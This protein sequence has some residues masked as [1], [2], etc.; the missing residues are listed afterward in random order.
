MQDTSMLDL[1]RQRVRDTT[2]DDRTLLSTDYFNHFNEVIM[3]LSMVGDMPDMLDEITAWTPKTYKQ[4]FE[5][6]GLAFAPLAIEAYD[7][8]PSEYR[9]PFDETVNEMN[10][11]IVEAVATLS[12][13]RDDPE[14][15]GFTAA[16]YWQRLQAL[17]DRGSAIVHG[18]VGDSNPAATLDQSQIDDLF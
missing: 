14:M 9:V 10:S 2:I 7:V 16:D 8:V 18:S 4:H 13:M 15:L 11:L 5:D 12:P 17:V 3:L 6:S 1:F